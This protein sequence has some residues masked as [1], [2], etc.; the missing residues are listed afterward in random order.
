MELSRRT[1]WLH[2]HHCLPIE[3]SLALDHRDVYERDCVYEIVKR[4][5]ASEMSMKRA[6]LGGKS[7]STLGDRQPQNCSLKRHIVNF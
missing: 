1:E 4:W 3:D 2:P 7:L 5:K 6:F